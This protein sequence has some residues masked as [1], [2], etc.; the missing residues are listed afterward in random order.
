MACVILLISLAAV[1][2]GCE[3]KDHTPPV[4]DQEQYYPQAVEAI[5]DGFISMSSANENAAGLL[6]YRFF[7]TLVWIESAEGTELDYTLVS[8][9]SFIVSYN[10]AFYVNEQRYLDALSRATEEQKR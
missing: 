1:L 8:D 2:G 9:M 6:R 7:E 4:M 3:D 10:G 5:P